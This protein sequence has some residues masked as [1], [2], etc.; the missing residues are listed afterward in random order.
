LKRLKRLKKIEKG[1]LIMIEEDELKKE[2]Q[3]IIDA[4]KVLLR[5]LILLNY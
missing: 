1:I 2:G 5:D 3:T 4:N